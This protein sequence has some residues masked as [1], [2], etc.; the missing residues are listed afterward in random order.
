[1]SIG[2][3]PQKSTQQCD[4]FQVRSPQIR[5]GKRAMVVEHGVSN[6]RLER[7]ETEVREFKVLVG[8]L[9]DWDR[10][11]V[12]DYVRARCRKD[13][14]RGSGRH[15][16][17]PDNQTFLTVECEHGAVLYDSRVDVPCDLEKS[18]RS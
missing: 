9:G 14:G 4:S 18:A 8:P 11:V 3:L 16:A 17:V 2:S 10:G 15:W 6:G 7:L 13:R 5:S 1:M 12:I